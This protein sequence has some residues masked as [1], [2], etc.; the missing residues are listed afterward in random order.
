MIKNDVTTIILFM[1][2][3]IEITL[4]SIEIAL[5]IFIIYK[6]GYLI[7]PIKEIITTVTEPLKTTVSR[8]KGKCQFCGNV[9]ASKTPDGYMACPGCKITKLH[10]L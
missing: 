9:G 1:I 10:Q 5:L 2:S 7:G 6:S 8:L 3:S 4:H